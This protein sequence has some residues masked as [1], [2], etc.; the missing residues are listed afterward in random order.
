M[1]GGSRPGSARSMIEAIVD[2]VVS[3]AEAFDDDAPV[4]LFPEEAAIVATTVLKRRTEFGTVRR[5]AR[6]ALHELGISPCPVVPGE[7]GAPVWPRGVVGSMTHCEGYRAAAV[8]RS[9]RIASI[10]I[11][12]E[13]DEPLPE[14]VL[15]IVS[16]PADRDALPTGGTVAWD[17][18]LFCAKEAVYKAWSPLTRTFLGF[19]E[20]HVT[21]DPG[22]AI[23]ASFLVEGPVVGGT[24]L[25]GFRGRWT[26]EGGFIAA[27]IMVPAG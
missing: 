10:G 24:L 9:L 1:V 17:R 6:L 20:A 19:D 8:A 4:E 13:P 11:D 2:R 14:G 12:A 21:L 15:D 3:V 5:L 26:A 16:V 27:A 18:L 23:H 25:T 7:R 22:G